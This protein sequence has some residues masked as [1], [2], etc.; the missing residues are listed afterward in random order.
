MSCLRAEKDFWEALSSQVDGRKMFLDFNETVA[1]HGGQRTAGNYDHEKKDWK[2]S[3]LHQ[4]CFLIGLVDDS[5][6]SLLLSN[7]GFR[8][9]SVVDRIVRSVAIE[10]IRPTFSMFTPLHDLPL[11]ITNALSLSFHKY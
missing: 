6:H 7:N 5:N 9:S 3:G 2:L 4:D 11:T 8:S 10:E 1:A